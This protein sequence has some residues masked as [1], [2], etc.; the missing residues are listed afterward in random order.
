MNFDVM[1]KIDIKVDEDNISQCVKGYYNIDINN[2]LDVVQG[3]S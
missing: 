2:L 1:V 3:S